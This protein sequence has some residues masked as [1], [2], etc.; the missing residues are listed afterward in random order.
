M[1]AVFFV[2]KIVLRFV[3][4]FQEETK[5]YYSVFPFAYFVAKGECFGIKG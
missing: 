1:R 2:S 4:Y 5:R 3:R